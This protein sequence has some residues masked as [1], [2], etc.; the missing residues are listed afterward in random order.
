MTN[1]MPGCLQCK[2]CVISEREDGLYGLYCERYLDNVPPVYQV[3]RARCHSFEYDPEEIDERKLSTKKEYKN[4]ENDTKKEHTVTTECK[5]CV[6][7]SNRTGMCHI[8][9]RN[10]EPSGYCY[11]GKKK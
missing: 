5:E 11:R 3:V 4:T 8:W 1:E 7:H 6:Y 9:F 10:T 2:H